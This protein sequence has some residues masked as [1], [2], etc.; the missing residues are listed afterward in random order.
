M[1]GVIPNVPSSN[2]NQIQRHRAEGL[3]PLR[4]GWGKK[5]TVD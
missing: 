2:K 3:G 1:L 4:K 5:G